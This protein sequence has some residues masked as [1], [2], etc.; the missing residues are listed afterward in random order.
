MRSNLAVFCDFDGTITTS[1]SDAALMRLLGVDDEAR[2]A[3]NRK[4]LDGEISIK[5]GY[6]QLIQCM[7]DRHTYEEALDITRKTYVFDPGFTQFFVWCKQEG[8]QLFVVSSG[9]RPS[10][11][12]A[13]ERH[14]GKEDAASI[15]ILSNEVTLP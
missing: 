2:L 14:L 1:E 6:Q 7:S 13:L 5:D 11:L 8:I 12:A 4:I 9:M 3:L 10:I 15:E